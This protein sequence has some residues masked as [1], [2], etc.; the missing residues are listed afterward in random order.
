MIRPSGTVTFLLTDIEGSTRRWETDAESMRSALTAHDEVLRSAIEAHGGWLFKHTGDGVCAA[1]G[2]AR[3]AI[4]AATDAQRRLG[5]PVRMGIATGEA[6]ERDGDYFGPALNRAARVMAVGHGGQILVAATTAALVDGADLLDLGERRLRDLS[7]AHRLFQVRGDGLAE[8]F[9]ELRTLDAV[10]GNLPVQSANLV[11]RELAVKE[12]AALIPAHRLVTLTGVGGVG[13]TRLA[14]QVAAELAGDFPDGVWLVE[15][16]PVG[17]PAAVPG[18]VATVLGVTPQAGS[19]VTESIANV[20]SGR[21]LLVVL[22][23]CEHVLDAAARLVDAILARAATVT[24]VATSREGLR[25]AAEWLWP[26]PSLNVGAN[27]GAAAVE[28]FVERARA[29]NPGFEVLEDAEMEAVTEI[30]RRLDGNALAIELAAARMMSM[31]PQDVRD[32]L[33]DRFR[34][35]AGPRRGLERHQTLRQ[36]VQWSY[37]LL[38]DNEKAVLSRCSVFADGFDLNAATHVC[39]GLDEYAVLDVL[40]SL[41]RKSLVSAERVSGHVR[42]GMLETIRQFAVDQLTAATNADEVRDCH[43][44]YFAEQA[45]AY[46]DVWDSPRQPVARAWFSAEFANLR[47][48]FRWACDR[49]EIATATAIAAHT[50]VVGYCLKRLEA[51]G[52][53]KELLPAATAANVRQLPRLYSRCR[54]LLVHRAPR[55]R[56]RLRPGRAGLGGRS[57]LRPVLEPGWSSMWA[58]A[59]TTTPVGPALHG[60]LRRHDRPARAR[61]R[62]RAVR[63]ALLTAA[64]GRPAEAMAIAEDTVAAA[65]AYGNPYWIAW[66]LPGTGAP[67]PRPILPGPW[68]P[69]VRGWPS[70][71]APHAPPGGNHRTGGRRTRSGARRTRAGTRVF[72]TTVDSFHRA[73]NIPNLADMLA[74]LAVFFDRFER[75]EIAATIY[76]TVPSDGISTTSVVDLTAVVDRLR[77]QLGDTAFMNG[78]PPGAAMGPAEAVLYAR[79]PVQ[80]VAQTAKVKQHGPTAPARTRPHD[81]PTDPPQTDAWSRWDD[82]N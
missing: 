35:L 82:V 49:G 62:S 59:S 9:P 6:Q 47:T 31:S 4:D 36:M 21:R 30:C 51:V 33:D 26:V 74:Y 43:A 37:D 54:A 1:F 27:A 17:D 81:A 13:K 77:T 2:S 72:D 76:G 11:G 60:G 7:G 44:R 50:A 41:V 42:Y 15:L 40:D 29:V 61:S 55:R 16:A 20:L 80:L 18:A 19:T 68:M 79:R 52:W 34:L 78:S 22:D 12:L 66:A 63:D 57:P 8:V 23:N 56:P 67:S 53:A 32:R 48:A 45:T 75:P 70:P 10:P 64:V 58:P 39:D 73:G 25:V 14:V 5:L 71:R 65:R 24:V 69:F 38:D 28:L 3:A 46:W